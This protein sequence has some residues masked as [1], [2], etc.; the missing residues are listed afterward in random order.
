MISRSPGLGESHG[1]FLLESAVTQHKLW[2]ARMA[3]KESSS[4][5]PAWAI[6][7]LSPASHWY[8][9]AAIVVHIEAEAI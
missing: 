1:G 9:A 3:S 2:V 7:M 8:T 6:E 5:M 4:R